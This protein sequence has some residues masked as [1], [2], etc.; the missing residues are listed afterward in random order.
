VN[1]EHLQRLAKKNFGKDLQGALREASGLNLDI[2]GIA[3]VLANKD[4]AGAFDVLRALLGGEAGGG[5]EELVLASPL[6]GGYTTESGGLASI[7]IDAPIATDGDARGLAVGDTMVFAVVWNGGDGVTFDS[8]PEGWEILVPTVSLGTRRMLVAAKQREP[9]DDA[10]YTFTLSGDASHRAVLAVVRGARPLEEWEVGTPGTRAGGSGSST[11]T[12]APSLSV[13][14]KGAVLAIAG[15]ATSAGSGSE[16]LVSVDGAD[17]WFFAAQGDA[18]SSAIET[19]AGAIAE[20]EEP[21]PSPA[22]TFTYANPQANNGAAVQIAAPSIV[23]PDGG[24]TIGDL[25]EDDPFVVA[26]RCNGGWW[27]ENTVYAARQASFYV[28][29]IGVDVWQTADGVWVCHHDQSTNRM[30]GQDLDI[31]TSN[32]EDLAELENL[33]T[34]CVD[35]DQPSRPMARLEEILDEFLPTH[36]IVVEKKGTSADMDD[37]L[38]FLEGYDARHKIVF[39]TFSGGQAQLT[40]AKAAGYVTWANSF[41]D[42]IENASW[43]GSNVDW[44]GLNHDASEGHWQTAVAYGK[45]VI[46]HVIGSLTQANS[47][48]TKGAVGLTVSRW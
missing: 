47:A 4:C 9:G 6:V 26:H 16:E 2:N 30:T 45:P 33:P 40:A 34:G 28:K 19:V 8:A 17:P 32:W 48:L 11:T 15:E 42:E 35:T 3:Q 25:L 27:P 12:V 31:P 23:V 1:T 37:F 5:D 7:E 46:G 39:Q 18:G 13:S 29:A 43:H 20:Q 21:G 10:D 22:V 24:W 44:I 14:A 41:D 36:V 38:D